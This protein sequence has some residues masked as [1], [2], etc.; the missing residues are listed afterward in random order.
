MF[1]SSSLLSSFLILLIIEN[2]K[3]SSKFIRRFTRVNI[4]ILCL[5]FFVIIIQQ[6][7][8]NTFFINI[9]SQ[10][11]S[12]YLNQS[13]NQI[14]LWSIYSWIGLLESGL[15]F[16]PILGSII[17]IQ[18]RKRTENKKIIAGLFIAG[19]IFSFLTKSRYIMLNMLMLIFLFVVYKKIQFVRLFRYAFLLVIFSMTAFFILDFSGVEVSSITNERIL[20]IEAGGVLS[21]SAGTRI[22]AFYVFNELFYNQPILGKGKLH[23]FD[24]QSK[25]YE[26]VDLLGKKSSQ[27]HVGYLSL[28]YYYGMVGGMLFLI[29]LF[30]FL[31]KLF[32]E[33]KLIGFWG[34]FFAIIIFSIDNLTLVE[35]SIFYSGIIISLV[36][37]QYFLNKYRN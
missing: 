27:I 10:S 24:G 25:D 14:R 26:L 13:E 16:V 22:Y 2:S 33:S 17:C 36:Y 4:F 28:F 3:F 11:V 6:L 37:H 7:I 31:K 19:F 30:L 5:A 35:F 29:F 1:Y 8:D 32:F 9:D 20:N 18:L 21:G 34:G 12:K 23:A 15:G